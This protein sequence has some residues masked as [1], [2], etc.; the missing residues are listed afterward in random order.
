MGADASKYFRSVHGS[1]C[2]AIDE[3]DDAVRW[4]YVDYDGD[5]GRQFYTP[6]HTPNTP[7]HTPKSFP[8]TPSRRH[9]LRWGK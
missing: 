8:S 3:G 4:V 1:R 7:A 9:N 2:L 5:G 6:A